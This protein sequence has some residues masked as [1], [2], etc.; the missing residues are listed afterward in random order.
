MHNA[1]VAARDFMGRCDITI[2]DSQ[3]VSVGLG[4]LWSVRGASTR[5][6]PS[7]SEVVRSVRE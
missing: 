7:M 5:R 2:L 4:C 3:T 1:R 6:A